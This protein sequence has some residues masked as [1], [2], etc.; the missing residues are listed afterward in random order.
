MNKGGEDLIKT[1][2]NGIDNYKSVDALLKGKRL[3]L[4]TNPTGTCKDM[5]ATIDLLNEKYTLTALYSPEHGVRGDAQAGAKILSGPDPLTGVM[6]YSLF[7]ETHYISAEMVKDG[8]MIV[9]DIQDVGARFYTYLY[10]MAYA[11]EACKKLGLPMLIFDRINPIGGV[12]IEG[13]ILDENFRSFVGDYSLPTRTGITLG[14]L[15]RYLAGTRPEQFGC[16]L[17]VVPVTGWT[18]D[19]YADETD[20]S[21]VIPS[22]NLPT[23]DGAEQYIG[24]C[25]FEG[26]NVSEGRGTTIP[27]QIIGAP[28]LKSYDV[29]AAMNEKH[30]PGVRF[31]AGCFTPTFSKHAGTLCYAV[32]PH[33]TDRR[34]YSSFATGLY[35]LEVIKDLHPGQ[36]EIA[37]RSTMDGPMSYGL[38]RLLGTD[39]FRTGELT[40]KE[41]IEYYK[42]G[43]AAY[44]EAIKPY[45]LYE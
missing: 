45:L 34:E 24:T 36:F 42:P 20:L 16:E 13:T 41:M 33:V 31:R 14:E 1:V 5:T 18:R 7:G 40:A 4:I 11:M 2:F 22:P 8:D 17:T 23:I 39:K 21:W 3:G 28:W 27:F 19:T 35:L 10:T 32:Q 29:V 15:A 6:N 30:L 12:K 38:D 44:R 25:V 43:I 37:G 9:V 26:T